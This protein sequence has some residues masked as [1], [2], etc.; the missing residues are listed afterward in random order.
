LNKRS[1]QGSDCQSFNQKEEMMTFKRSLAGLASAGAVA[2]LCS[3]AAMA[4][5]TT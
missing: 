5:T 3:T 4:E 1:I 2:V